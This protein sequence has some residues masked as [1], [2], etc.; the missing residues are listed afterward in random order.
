M[1]ITTVVIWIIIIIKAFRQ[2]KSFLTIIIGIIIR[3]VGAAFA[4]QWAKQVF[5][6]LFNFNK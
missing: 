3:I 6:G 1:P 4:S 5:L 2:G